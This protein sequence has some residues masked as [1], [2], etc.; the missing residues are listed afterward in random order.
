MALNSSGAISLGGSTAG[1]SV[2]L[3]LGQAAGATITMN[4]TNLRA[5]FGVASGTISLSQGYG[6]S[7]YA[8]GGTKGLWAGGDTGP[9]TAMQ[10]QIDGITF[11]TEAAIDP[12]AALAQARRSVS[13]INNTTTGYFVGGR[14][15]PN[16]PA[17]G[18]D[19]IDGI[20]FATEAAINP[21]AA[22]SQPRYGAAS[23]N[24]AAKGYFAGGLNNLA[25]P[26]G[27][28][29]TDILGLTFSTET[30]FDP[31]ASLAVAR[32]NFAGVN[33]KDTGFAAGG[34][35]TPTVTTTEIDGLTFATEAAINPAAA[36]AQARAGVGGAGSSTRGYFAGGGT[37]TQ[38]DGII[39]SSQAAFDPA[40][41]LAQA[42][43]VAGVNSS[44]LALYGSGAPSISTGAQIDGIRFSDEASVNP[45][46]ALAQARRYAGST[47]DSNN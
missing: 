14:T 35:S 41:A 40:A 36:L 24:S 18:V 39:F 17:G 20:T 28:R 47:Q 21:A 16:T 4:D 23:F 8:Y 46:A 42:R 11:A 44:T 1:Q 27:T 9:S 3:E 33:D 38:I 25:P 15:T 13:G 45:A 2:N 43:W 26:A 5:L 12:A 19:Q 10:N 32:F 34:E 22:L 31:A 30:L 29:T 7:S 37:V 6:K